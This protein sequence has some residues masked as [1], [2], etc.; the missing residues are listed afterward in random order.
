[1]KTLLRLL[2]F[3][4]V[5]GAAGPALAQS[6]DPSAAPAPPPASGETRP[7]TNTFLG[8]T[9][10][11]FVPTGEVL[12]A[13]KASGG[14]YYVN[15]DFSEAFMDVA[16]F[17]GVVGYGIKNKA[18]VFGAF[19]FYR[20][21]DTDSRPLQITGSPVGYPNPVEGWQTGVGD[22]YVGGKVNFMSQ[23]DLKPAA[24]AVRGVLK[25]PTASYSDG[26]GT[27]Q[28][29]FL[30][31]AIV[32]KEVNEKVEVSGYGGFAFRKSPDNLSTS[33]GF[34]YGLGVAVPTRGSFR[35]TAEAYG[36]KY[37]D[38]SI[39]NSGVC[40]TAAVFDRPASWNVKSPFNTFFGVDYQSKSGFFAGA[41][42]GWN[43]NFDGREKYNQGSNE[44][45]D[46][47]QG[48]VRIGY[49]P[50]VRVHYVA[51]PPPAA[52]P[53]PMAPSNH[54]PTVKAK[55]DPCVVQVGKSST[56]SADAQDP[57]GDRL[58]CRW[59]TPTGSLA[60]PM[61][62]STLWT[63][64]EQEGSVPVT[65]TCDDGKG[66]TASDTV[67]IQV[68]K[69]P[70]K[71]TS[72]RTSTSTSTATRCGRKRRACSTKRS[73]RWPTIQSSRSRSRATPATSARRNTT[74]RSANGARG[75]CSTT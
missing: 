40:C 51:P 64:P 54:P 1:M 3:S 43:L 46:N 27:G 56:V 2:V 21:I 39:T 8:D 37:F 26:L 23:A 48:S 74:W 11:W 7:A 9:G 58:N 55:C 12:P 63:A 73:R 17:S 14:A 20:R 32:S 60:N 36:E 42:V 47:L 61:Q 57:D 29:D 16:D 25:L 70:V 65:I 33:N 10:L 34:R 38:G 44:G 59:S 30:V 66:G 50:G 67:N 62:L 71:D 35:F 18:E 24:V 4:V 53:P 22:I 52:P 72:S 75:R 41:G 6:T 13:K 69:A 49:H 19:Q 15:Q 68:V 31:D 5:A 28:P 45:G